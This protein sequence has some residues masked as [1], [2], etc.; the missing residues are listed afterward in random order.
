MTTESKLPTVLL[1]ML[2]GIVLLL[3]VAIIGLFVRMNQLQEAV[4]AAPPVVR[5][6]GADV[7]R[8]RSATW[9]TR[10]GGDRGQGVCQHAGATGGAG[11]R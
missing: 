8:R 11:G 5:V 6:Y 10:R 4:L 1:L 2:T 7:G 9:W 3:M